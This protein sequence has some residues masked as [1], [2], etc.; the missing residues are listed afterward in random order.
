MSFQVCIVGRPNVGKSSLLNALLGYRR[1]IV[2][3]TPGTTVD[4]VSELTEWCEGRLKISDSQ[5]VFGEE[6]EETLVKFI[7]K[8]DVFLFVVDARQGPTPYDSWIAKKLLR[9]NKP[10]LLCLN[11]AENLHEEVRWDFAKVVFE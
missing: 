10:T 3:D 4:E 5:G 6:N 11:K 9:T 1:A 8:A 7:A 2:C